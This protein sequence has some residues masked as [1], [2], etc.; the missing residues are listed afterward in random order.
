MP[1]FT[2]TVFE[3]TSLQRTKTFQANSADAAGELAQDDLDT[4]ST[5]D[6]TV[7]RSDADVFIDA[8]E[9]TAS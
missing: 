2:V 9:P 4:G 6:W 1:A 5:A 8:I 7:T 3:Q